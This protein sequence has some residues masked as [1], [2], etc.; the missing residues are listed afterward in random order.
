MQTNRNKKLRKKSWA[1]LF[2]STSEG[3]GE[4]CRNRFFVTE[5]DH[6]GATQSGN[7]TGRP[8]ARSTYT[9]LLLKVTS[10][11]LSSLLISLPESVID[12]LPMSSTLWAI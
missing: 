7:D 9:V 2:K 5:G 1:C 10:S 6:F 8:L 4:N 11:L 3:C 12:V